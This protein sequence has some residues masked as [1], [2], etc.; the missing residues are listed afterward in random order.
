MVT[1]APMSGDWFHQHFGTSAMGLRLTA[2][3]GPHAPGREPGV[4]GEED[5]DRG[6]IELQEGGSAI[7]YWDEDPYLREEFRSELQ[8]EGVDSRMEDRFYER[9]AGL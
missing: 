5:I 1:A 6:A 3:F 4:P 9:P 8:A 2:W 7:P